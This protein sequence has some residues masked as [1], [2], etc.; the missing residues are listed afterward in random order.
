MYVLK[1]PRLIFL[2]HVRTAS[3]SIVKYLEENYELSQMS[4]RPNFPLMW[5]D[6]HSVDLV[7]WD[8]MTQRRYETFCVVRN[9]WDW[10]LSVA[11][12]SGGIPQGDPSPAFFEKWIETKLN[13]YLYIQQEADP[14]HN[15]WRVDRRNRR[16]F[17][18]YPQ[19]SDHVLRF[20]TLKKDLGEMLG[21]R[22]VNLPKIGATNR[23]SHISAYYTE[24]A[25]EL[26]HTQFKEE[27]MEYGYEFPVTKSQTRRLDVQKKIVILDPDMDPALVEE[28]MQTDTAEGTV[29]KAAIEGGL[30][31]EESIPEPV[32]KVQKILADK[33]PKLPPKKKTQRKPVTKKTV[34]KSVKK[35]S[36]Y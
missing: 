35:G 33:H 1:R 26:V 12:F 5:G 4:A 3:Q 7:N 6:H 36:G 14:W 34:K 16:A 15:R 25:K 19:L 30:L 20:E 17:W 32:T 28:I 22:E 29:I 31:D 8:D 27:I 2:A 18:L 9:H 21:T 24:L 10:V 11:M 23:P 13:K